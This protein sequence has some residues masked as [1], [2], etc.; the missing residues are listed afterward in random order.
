MTNYEKCLNV[1][2]I[3]DLVLLSESYFVFFSF[4]TA[5]DK[6]KKFEIQGYKTILNTKSKNYLLF[7]F[8]N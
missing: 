7:I 8:N 2:K 1:K 3:S 5:N 4:K 6:R